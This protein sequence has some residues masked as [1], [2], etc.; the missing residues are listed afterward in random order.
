MYCVFNV[1]PP[2]SCFIAVPGPF[3]EHAFLCAGV[4]TMRQRSDYSVKQ[5]VL[6]YLYSVYRSRESPCMH[7]GEA[8]ENRRMGF[9]GYEVRRQCQSA[10]GFQGKKR[11]PCTAGKQ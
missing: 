11:M 9:E 1:G 5:I 8:E 7:R 6:L 2:I 10:A 4:M 3:L